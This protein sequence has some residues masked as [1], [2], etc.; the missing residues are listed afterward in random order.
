MLCRFEISAWPA[1]YTISSVIDLKLSCR[2]S[3]H[4]YSFSFRVE[5]ISEH[6]P[7]LFNLT[8]YIMPYLTALNSLHTRLLFFQGVS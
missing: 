1:A 6:L 3:L 7:R 4:F 8:D 2:N 5:A